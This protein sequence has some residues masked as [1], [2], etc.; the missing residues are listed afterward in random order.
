VDAASVTTKA[1]LEYWV[2]LALAYNKIAKPSRKKKNDIQFLNQAFA[3]LD[4]NSIGFENIARGA[5]E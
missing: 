2:N 4:R 5:R 3:I 1:K